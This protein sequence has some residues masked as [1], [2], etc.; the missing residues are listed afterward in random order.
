MYAHADKPQS[1]EGFLGFGRSELQHPDIFIPAQGVISMFVL[2]V[3]DFP[4]AT[5]TQTPTHESCCRVG[6]A[7]FPA[8]IHNGI[9][10]VLGDPIHCSFT[11]ATDGHHPKDGSSAAQVFHNSIH[12]PL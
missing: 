10:P 11:N 8:L 7:V 12:L 2:Q 5:S 6:Y 4:P 3:D 1:T 9:G